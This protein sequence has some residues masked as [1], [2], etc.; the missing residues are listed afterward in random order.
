MD[1]DPRARPRRVDGGR[2]PAWLRRGVLVVLVAVAGYQVV[3]WAFSNLRGFLGLVF[4][5]WLFSV[6]VEPLVERLE[7]LGLRRGAATGLV[8]SALVAALAGF[9]AAFGSLLVEQLTSLFTA[10]PDVA[11]EVV[12]WVNR[13]FD[14]TLDPTDVV[15][16]LQLSSARIQ[17][18]V[19]DLTPGVVGLV[20]TLV[21]LLFQLLTF[22]LFAFYMSAEG[23]SL[24]ASVARRFPPRQQRVVA[25]VWAIAVEKTGGFVVSRLVLAAVS[26]VV[27]GLFLL[28]LGVP[29][30]LPLALW[31]GVISQFIPTIGTYLAI[32]VPALIALS[33]QPVDALWVVLFGVVYQ[34]V[35]N[36]LLAPRITARTVA[37][38][39]AVAFGS[40][41]VGAALFG[42]MGALVSIPVVAAVQ[43]VVETYGHRYELVA[44]DDDPDPAPG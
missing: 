26:A 1:G 24:R 33:G 12:T 42:P 11:R 13:T 29:Y 35:E 17:Q 22:L 2:E 4:L 5:A 43:A 31:T 3:S 18:I 30:W 19:A 36:Y 15:S 32:G 8:L 9:V 44:D 16:S 10:L 38:H 40:V 21:G 28:L 41:V 34:Q 23:P 39:P 27:T 14:T 6:S 37:I 20:T 25:T 7:R